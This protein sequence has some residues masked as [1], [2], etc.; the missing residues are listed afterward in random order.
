VACLGHSSKFASLYAALGLPAEAL[1]N[2][3][4][5]DRG[6]FTEVLSTVL[7]RQDFARLPDASGTLRSFREKN[8]AFAA[9]I[10]QA[11]LTGGWQIRSHHLAKWKRRDIKGR[12]WPSLRHLA[13]RVVRGA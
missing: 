9:S 1:F 11:G 13:R 8:T 4:R 10:A 3:D 12:L 2:Y 6:S 5:S 7:A